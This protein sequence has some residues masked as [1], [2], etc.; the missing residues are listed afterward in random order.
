MK[1]LVLFIFILILINSVFISSLDLSP[2]EVR[3]TIVNKTN[4]TNNPGAGGANSGSEGGSINNPQAGGLEECISQWDC[5]P[6]E[7]CT[8][9]LTTRECKDVN[10]CKTNPIKIEQ[11]F[12]ISKEDV[13]KIAKSPTFW[14][15]L[16]IIIIF[17]I[18]SW[19]I[20][21]RIKYK[22]KKRK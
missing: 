20:L 9:L 16:I 12:C 8:N 18:L 6:W 22:K 2:T 4:T 5:S 21:K 13:N 14:I 17:L 3:V 11:Q 10:S 19:I 7:N 15:W 1:N